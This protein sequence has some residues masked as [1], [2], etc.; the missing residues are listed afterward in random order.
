MEQTK[1]VEASPALLN[2]C[3]Y[4]RKSTEAED[5][6]ALSIESQVKEMLALAKRDNLRIVEVKRESHSSK[7]V[8][9]RPV[10]NQMLAE[11][12]EGKFNSILTWAPD[13]LSRN[14]GDL[15]SVVDLID[16]KLLL[17]IRTYGQKFGNN[18][19]EKFLLMILGSQAKLENDNK[20]V[21]V[22]RGLRT[23]CEMGLRPGVAPTGYLNEKHVDKKCQVRIDLKRAPVIKQMFEKVAHEQW[24]GRKTYRWLR[25]IGFKTKSGK[26]LV[27]ANIYLILRNTFYYGEF[28]YPVGGGKWYTGKHAPIIDKELFEKVQN[29]LNENY[30]PKTESKEFAFTKLIKCGYCGSGISADE[31]FKKLKDGGVNRHVYYFCS[32]ARNI[33][34][35]N[36]AINEP[37]LIGELIQ[38]MDTVNLDELEVKTRIEQEIARYNKF[39]VGVLGHKQEKADV[40]VDA[41][42]YAKYL[43]REGTLLEKRE[44]LSCLQSKLTLR[45]KKISLG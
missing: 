23:R 39:R 16:Q 36:P 26:P 34:C 28:E 13:R 35:K 45:D 27:L 40:G 24:S 22:K 21:N 42:N 30:V 9:Q 3:L 41:R 19:N 31:K 2:Y 25:E 38:L 11:V 17:E 1:R 15:G 4:A 14:A 37:S 20:A 5:K 7:E 43:L 6:Q 33:D 32:K 12:R 8:G 10:F 18:P 29:S 44:L